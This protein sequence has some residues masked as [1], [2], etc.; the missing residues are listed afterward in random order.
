[1]QVFGFEIEVLQLG[2][3]PKGKSNGLLHECCFACP[4]VTE[5]G[6]CGLSFEVLTKD[7]NAIEKAANGCPIKGVTHE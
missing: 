2:T 3:Q 1:M 5:L 7:S 6:D 4:W